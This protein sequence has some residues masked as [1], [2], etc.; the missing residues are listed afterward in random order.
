MLLLVGTMLAGVVLSSLSFGDMVLKAIGGTPSPST[1][2]PS[3]PPDDD[4]RPPMT[5]EERADGLADAGLLVGLAVRPLITML[6]PVMDMA[7]P[8]FVEAAGRALCGLLCNVAAGLA[9]G[10]LLLLV[11]KVCLP[12]E[13]LPPA[14]FG[15]GEVGFTAEGMASA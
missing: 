3:R 14:V 6:R 12:E 5:D 7:P 15:L 13:T 11:P 2:S 1:P 10:A 8:G 4:E 9:G